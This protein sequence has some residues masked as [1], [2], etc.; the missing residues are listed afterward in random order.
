LSAWDNYI[1]LSVDT[2]SR[3]G[4]Y[5]N[6]LPGVTIA[7][8]DD[9]TKDEQEDLDQCFS[10]LYETA[11]LNFTTDVQGKIG[12][13]FHYDQ[14]LVTRET[15]KFLDS[16]NASTGP[17]G[18]KIESSLPKYARLHLISAEV[19]S[20]DAYESPELEI[21]VYDTDEDGEVLLTKSSEISV[22]RN[23][24]NIDSDFEADK[25][26]IVY[27]PTMFDLRKSENKYY[28]TLG[29]HYD[30]LSCTYPCGYGNDG[31]AISVLQFNNGGLNLKF[32]VSCS[33]DKFICENINIFKTAFWYRIGVDL[34]R[35]RILS[36]RFNRFTLFTEE[37]AE[38][39]KKEYME[40]YEVNLNNSI[41]SVNINEDPICF[42]CKNIV[43]SS[44]LIP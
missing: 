38:Q 42:E 24:I 16:V 20:E 23:V 34:M 17:S 33:I 6:R 7:L 36:D 41:D 32:V 13:K 14:K 11:K 5:A 30:K 40:L 15:S 29:A 3:S 31:Y 19:F 12:K 1:T 25:L 18:I 2:P 27:D 26:L 8:F 4:L 10:D 44:T 37:R 39:L 28:N 21:T 35:E 9:L 22:G 43:E